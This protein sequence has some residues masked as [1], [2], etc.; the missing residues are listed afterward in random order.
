MVKVVGDP[1]VSSKFYI[2]NSKG[3][4][5]WVPVYSLAESYVKR[6]DM[7]EWYG[8]T[9]YCTNEEFVTNRDGLLVLASEVEHDQAGTKIQL[10][11]ALRVQFETTVIDLLN[12]TA[13]KNEYENYST[14]ISWINSSVEKYKNFATK[15]YAYRDTL[16]TYVEETEDRLAKTS[17][18]DMDSIDTIIKEFLTN[19][20]QFED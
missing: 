10:L 18:E 1:K 17:P 12:E 3:S 9:I 2:V 15:L 20:P 14:A 11:N 7:K 6:A 16:Y 19:L 13:R 5:E 4:I 8:K